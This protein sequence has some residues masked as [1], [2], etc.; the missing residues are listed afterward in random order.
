[1][2]TKESPESF[3]N[4]IDDLKRTNEEL[5]A[6]LNDALN[7]N[8][9]FTENE[10]FL[11]DCAVELVKFPPDMDIYDF[12]A[13]KMKELFPDSIVMVTAYDEKSEVFGLASLKGLGKTETK[14]LSKILGKNFME[15][16]ISFNNMD[17]I[18]QKCLYTPHFKQLKRGLYAATGGI[19]SK[20]RCQLVEKVAGINEVYG[21]GILWDNW[22]YGAVSIFPF[23]ENPLD[24]K[25]I[26]ETIVNMISVA[27]Q[28]K[29]AE[30]QMK[31][32]LKEKEVLMREIHHRSKN[33]LAIISSLLNIQSK[34]I[35][36]REARA[37]IKESQNR[38][39]S[40]AL[41]H[42]HLYSSNDLKN[43]NFGEYLKI[44]ASNLFKSYLENSKN[45]KLNLN[46]ENNMLDVDTAVSLGLITN[47]LITNSIKYAFPDENN[48]EISL[49]FYK[50]NGIFNF[51]IK[52]NGVG[53]SDDLDFLNS[54][55]MGLRVVNMLISQIEGD[56]KLNNDN[57]TE[58]IITFKEIY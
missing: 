11:S 35:K 53:F 4:E 30:N 13:S 51:I 5:K 43:F 12:T 2:N 25:D 8:R 15:A 39:Q 20:R 36:D 41:I 33:N 38:A 44:L 46:I 16:E 1:M 14:L 23:N 58:F 49:E 37:I 27:L 10:H 56:V 3:L 28:R 52:D 40:M 29:K 47:E 19:F 55:S 6:A 9:E 54:S 17:E 42:E 48:G 22:L 50:S 34:N 45:I 24:K 32:A 26:V 21:M 57:G 7:Y 31:K 18:I